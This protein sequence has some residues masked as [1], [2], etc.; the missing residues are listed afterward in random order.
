[1]GI[2]QPTDD[3]LQDYGLYV[4]EQMLQEI[5]HSLAQWPSM[6]CSTGGWDLHTTNP[7]ISEQLDYNPQSEHEKAIEKVSQFN[8]DQLDAYNTVIDSISNKSGQLFFLHGPAGTGKTYVYNGLCNFVRSKSWVVLEVASSGISA[9]LIAGGRT[10]HSMFKIPIHD[11]TSTSFCAIP[12]NSLRAELIRHTKLIIWDEIGPQ[13]RNCAEALDRTC[14][15]IRNDDRPFGGI[16]VVFGGDFQQTLPVVKGGSRDDIIDACLQQSYL[17]KNIT[18]LSLRINMRLLGTVDVDAEDIEFANWLLQV[19]HGR[20]MEE[21][22]GEIPL[23][24][25]RMIT[26]SSEDLVNFIYGDI[27]TNPP[28]PPEYFLNR[29]ILAARNSDVAEM[30]KEILQKMIGETKTYLSADSL[31]YEEGADDPHLRDPNAPPIPSEFLRSIN[32]SSLPP[33]ELP[34]KTGCPV[35]LLRNLAPSQ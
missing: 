12:K 6:P 26:H 28:P 29:T 17:W 1:M 9:L 31:I 3:Q 27:S 22:S 10:A 13:H 20:D 11:L 35:I 21:D 23:P 33:G 14:R 32:T 4:L 7:L 34:L 30:N 15:D 16:T 24:D 8:A 19:G 2:Q 25:S 5:G 18:I